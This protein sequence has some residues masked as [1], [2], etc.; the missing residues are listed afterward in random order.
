MPQELLA[1]PLEPAPSR[2]T[3]TTTWGFV[4]GGIA[5]EPG[6]GSEPAGSRRSQAF[7]AGPTDSLDG[8]GLSSHFKPLNSSAPGSSALV[9]CSPQA[10][11]NLLQ[12]LRRE[13]PLGLPATFAGSRSAKM[14][15]DE[16]ARGDGTNCNCH[17]QR[18]EPESGL[19]QSKRKSSSPGYQ[20]VPFISRFHSREGTSPLISPEKVDYPSSRP[21]PNC[22]AKT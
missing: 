18:C 19:V 3:A 15:L 1:A 21:S 9:H 22:L 2:I 14:R 7:P 8:T 10:S 16:A 6:R 13:Q 5:D 12:L 11:P 17:L 4:C 20:G